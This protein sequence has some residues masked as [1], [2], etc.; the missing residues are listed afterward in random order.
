M[1]WMVVRGTESDTD[2]DA[3]KVSMDITGLSIA[4]PNPFFKR[5]QDRDSVLF[6]KESEGKFNAYSRACPWNVRRQP[7]MLTNEEKSSY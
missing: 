2:D 1:I 7:V 3:D 5:M 6:L 4:N